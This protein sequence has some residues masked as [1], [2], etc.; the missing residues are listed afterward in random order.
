MKTHFYY[1]LALVLAN[2]GMQAQDPSNADLRKYITGSEER[3]QSLNE[4]KFGLFIH[5]GPYAVP[6]GEWHSERIRRLGEWIM[7]NAKIPVAE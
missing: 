2:I 3:L 7:Y 1:C 5:W 6:A 4:A